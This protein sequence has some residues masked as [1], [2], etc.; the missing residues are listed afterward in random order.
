MTTYKANFKYRP[1]RND[2]NASIIEQ[3]LRNFVS[4]KYI[5]TKTG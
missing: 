1:T 5:S 2:L 3:K 4:T